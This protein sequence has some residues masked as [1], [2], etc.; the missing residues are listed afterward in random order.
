MGKDGLAGLA[1]S[2]SPV[3]GFS[4]GGVLGGT[5]LID[6]PGPHGPVC[7]ERGP[8]G[9]SLCFPGVPGCFRFMGKEGTGLS[10]SQAF[11]LCSL[12]P[13]QG[14][15][16]TVALTEALVFAAQE[17]SPRESLQVS[18]SGTIPGSMVAA[19]PSSAR[20]SSVVATPASVVTPTPPP[21]GPSS[22][23]TAP[24]AT[25]APHPDGHPPTKPQ[26]H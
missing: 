17:P 2:G 19:S 3:V 16:L 18:P 4:L 26:H 9:S 21:D 13:S 14:F 12:S 7:S 22:Q 5:S 6:N 11:H 1:V 20:H 15:L 8:Q 25:T 10:C 23:A 24:M